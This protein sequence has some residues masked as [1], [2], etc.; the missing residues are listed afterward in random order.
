MFVE[1]QPHVELGARHSTLGTRDVEP[2]E[3]RVVTADGRVHDVLLPSGLQVDPQ[4]RARFEQ[5]GTHR[6]RRE[7][8]GQALEP[9]PA[10]PQ[11]GV[12]AS[13]HEETTQWLPSIAFSGLS[14]ICPSRK[15]NAASLPSTSYPLSAEAS[16]L[17]VELRFTVKPSG[18]SSTAL[19]VSGTSC[20]PWCR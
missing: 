13:G 19:T 10:A 6:Q 9:S 11:R 2:A 7:R 1:L 15:I 18:Y 20:V 5:R 16:L 8:K 3:P 14:T 12:R 17:K 4:P